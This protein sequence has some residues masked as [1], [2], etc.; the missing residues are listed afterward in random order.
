MAARRLSQRTGLPF[1]LTFHGSDMNVWPDAHPE[2]LPSLR[3][4]VREASAVFAVSRALAERIRELTGVEAIHLPIGIDD[5]TIRQVRSDDRLRSRR[6]RGY[7]DD[8]IVALFVGN[9]LPGKGS[10]YLAEAILGLDDRFRATFLGGGPMAGVGA[11]DPRA[12]GRLDY[13]GIQPHAEVIRTMEAADV[14]ILPSSS[15]GLPTVVVEAGAVGLPVIA[16]RAGGIPELLEPDRGTL[17]DA[18]T[19]PAVATALLDFVERPSATL[20]AAMR[21]KDHVAAAYDSRRQ[22]DSLLGWYRQV[23]GSSV[24]V[25]AHERGDSVRAHAEDHR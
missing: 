22:A 5:A 2:W 3:V 8:Q 17:L 7:G 16:S 1:V 9:L 21:L 24:R 20:D 4:A 10:Q 14:L 23:V 18:L 12:R 11:M 13:R 19:G 25:A 15:E 6:E